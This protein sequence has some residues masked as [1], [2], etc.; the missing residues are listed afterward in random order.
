MPNPFTALLLSLVLPASALVTVAAP[1]DDIVTRLQHLPN[2][3]YL[4]E[5]PSP[6]AGFREFNLEFRQPVDHRHPGAGTFEQQVTVLHRDIAAP[7]VV[8][9]SGYFNYESIGFTYVTEPTKLTGGN[10]LDIEHRFFANSLPMPTDWT[11]LTIWQEASDEH[12]IVQT[13]RHIYQKPW[14]ATGISKGGMTAVYHDRFYPNDYT[15]T[16]AYSSPNDITN[17]GDAYINFLAQVGTPQCEADLRR[18][19]IEALQQRA[20][21]ET[22]MQEAADA[23]GATFTDIGSLDEAYE[24]DIIDTPFVFWQ[25]YNNESASCATIPPA[26]APVAD[27]YNFFDTAGGTTP[28]GMLNDS[29]QGEELFQPYN[30]QAGTQLDYPVEPQS[31]LLGLLHFPNQESARAYVP[32]SIP[33]RFDPTVMPDID[34]WVRTQGAHLIF[35]YGSLDPY[36]ATPFRLGPGTR[37]SAVYV[38]PGGDHLTLITS[39]TT[40]QQQQITAT[41]RRWAGLPPTAAM[42]AQLPTDAQQRSALMSGVG[43]R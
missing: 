33:M 40:A 6:P 13:F 27:L 42:T 39:L 14:L 18:V 16:L 3:T 12:A 26:G 21:M 31:Y 4:N 25:F 29:D 35:T 5:N 15:G 41:L 20:P 30:Y 32:K 23:A 38:K 43:S 1:A 28:G 9:T 10:Q 34:H 11:D 37:D 24:F 17:R 22:L 8:F 19:Q 7:M 36:G 2:V